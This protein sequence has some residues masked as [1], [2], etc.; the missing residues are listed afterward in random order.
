[1]WLSGTAFFYTYHRVYSPVHFGRKYDRSGKYIRDWL[2]E[3][4]RFPAKYIYAPWQAPGE[5]QREAGCLIGTDYPSPICDLDDAKGANLSKMDEAYLAAPAAWKVLIPQAAAT[6][7]NRER[8][9]DLSTSARGRKFI[10][11]QQ[12]HEQTA[13]PSPSSTP[14]PVA[15]IVA[16]DRRPR[17]SGLTKAKWGTRS[18]ARND[19]G[20][21]KPRRRSAGRVQHSYLAS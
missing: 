8:G 9:V 5:V 6:E 2:P 4:R 3:L 15:R 21:Q 13:A 7:V 18:R 12:G 17:S 10:P 1:M 19:C 16:T 14:P 20:E 11:I